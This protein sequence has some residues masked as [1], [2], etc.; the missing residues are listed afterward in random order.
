MTTL[1]LGLFLKAWP[2]ILGAFGLLGWG[3]AQRRSGAKAER[4]KSAL[5]E[6]K[7][8]DVADEVDNDI[9]AL[10]PEQAREALRKWSRR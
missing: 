2:F 1:L 7:A 9:G 8:R 10:T 4:A 5:R 3:I 6:A